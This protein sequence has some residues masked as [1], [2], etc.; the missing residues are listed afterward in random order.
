MAR[1]K[2]RYRAVVLGAS[3]GGLD[4]LR[5]VA[6]GLRKS[7]PLPFVAALHIGEDAHDGTARVLA[8]HSKIPIAAVSDGIKLEPGQL[9]LAPAGYH[10]LVERDGR[11]ALSVDDRVGFSRPSIDVLLESAAD[12]YRNELVAIILTGANNDG[13]A[14]M[15]AARS[16]NALCVVQDPASAEVPVMPAAA[17]ASAGADHVLDLDGIVALLNQLQAADP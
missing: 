16:R 4:A 5:R 15:L 11:L 9:Y 12:A 1:A 3:A 17:L 14:G 7:F 10:L 2:R 8:P 6:S 13:A